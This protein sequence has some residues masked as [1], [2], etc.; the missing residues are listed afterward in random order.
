MIR[1]SNFLCIA[2]MTI[3]LSACWDQNLLKDVRLY[4]AAS[5]DL[6][7]D[8]RII[9]TVSSPIIKKA[10]QGEGSAETYQ[11]ITG[12]GDTPRKARGDIDKRVSKTFDASKLRVLIIGNKLAKEDIYPVLD[13][14]YRDPK[15]SLSAKVVIAEGMGKGILELNIKDQ[16]ISEYLFELLESQ[17]DSLLIP[18]ENIQSICAEMFDP[19]EDLSLPYISQEEGGALANVEGI[20]LFNERKFTGHI[21]SGDEAEIFLLMDGHTGKTVSFTKKIANHDDSDL[22]EFVS[23]NVKKAKK[24]LEVTI[25]NE[26]VKVNINLKLKISLTEYARNQLYNKQEIKFLNEELSEILTKDAETAIKKLQE[27]NSDS[28]GIGRRLISLHNDYW[29]RVDWKSVYPNISITPKVNVEI[30][31]HGIIE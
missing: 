9:D 4:L 16:K 26:E 8:G 24:R 5:F 14:F 7:T 18:E 23:L 31:G 2:F 13:L 22:R 1:P 28:F 27:A 17:E 21:L 6:D 29:Q 19:G 20:A 10:D 11:I 25:E 3:F 15:S 30:I 12:I